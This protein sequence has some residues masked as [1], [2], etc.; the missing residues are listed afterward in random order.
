M[1]GYE[2]KNGEYSVK[3][4]KDCCRDGGGGGFEGG[5]GGGEDPEDR[6]LDDTTIFTFLRVGVGGMSSEQPSA[7]RG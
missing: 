1:R 5:R 4:N 2:G 7:G 3:E 6:R